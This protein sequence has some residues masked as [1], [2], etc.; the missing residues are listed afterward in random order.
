MLLVCDCGNV[1]TCCPAY[2]PLFKE[3]QRFSI[4]LSDL[5]LAAT[6]YILSRWDFYTVL[7]YYGVPW[8]LL[9]HWLVI[10]TYLHH[11]DQ[12]V[13]HYRK[14]ARNFVRGAAA[15]IDRD[16]L[17]WQGRFFFHGTNHWHIVHHFFPRIPFC[18]SLVKG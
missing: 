3:G 15:T 10:I 14:E 8:L 4:V 13:P 16:V 1:L 17:G 2:S 6:L 18:K 9:S 7:R 5:G 12:G 11:A